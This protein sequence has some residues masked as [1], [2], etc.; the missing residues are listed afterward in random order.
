MVAAVEVGGG[1]CLAWRLCQNVDVSSGGCSAM[2]K[3]GRLLGCEV[4]V[5]VDAELEG[6]LR[7]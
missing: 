5:V 4:S 1:P 6:S 3:L 7:F 2:F